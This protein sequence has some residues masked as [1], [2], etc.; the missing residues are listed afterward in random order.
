MATDN[1]DKTNEVMQWI[2][3][4]I[5]ALKNGDKA[6]ITSHPTPIIQIHT[7]SSGDDIVSQQISLNCNIRSPLAVHTKGRPPL[8]RKQS[9][10]EQIVLKLKE[11]KKKEKGKKEKKEKEKEKE[12]H[13]MHDA[14]RGAGLCPQ[15]P[16]TF[17][18][19]ELHP[20]Q[21][22]NAF[23]GAGICPQMPNAFHG[24]GCHSIYECS[25]LSWSLE[26]ETD[27]QKWVS[28]NVENHRKKTTLGTEAVAGR[29]KVVLDSKLRKAEL[30]K[31][32]MTVCQ[33]GSCDFKSI[34]EAIDSIPLNN[35]KRVILEIKPGLYR[36]KIVIPMEMPFITFLG[37]SLNPPTIT[38]NDT[39]SAK[40]MDGR[41]LKTFHRATVAV[42]SN[43]FVAI[44]IIFEV[45]VPDPFGSGSG[46]SIGSSDPV[47][48]GSAG[49]RGY[50]PVLSY[51]FFIFSHKTYLYFIFSGLHYFKNCFIQGSVDFIFGY[52]RSLYE[53]CYLNSVAK[54][55]A[56]VTAQKRTNSSMS[57]G[58]S[59]K[60][61]VVTGSGL[62]YLGRAWGDRS[63]VVF[64][65]TFMDKVVMSQGWND[66]GDQKRETSSLSWSLERESDYQKWVSWNVENHRKQTI[67]GTEA[68]A[69]RGKTELDWKL[70]KAELH[71]VRMT[72]SQD[73]SCDFK[74]IREAIESIPLNNTK[75]VILEIKPGLYREKIV[76]PMEMPFITFLGDSLNPP[77]ITGNDTASTKGQDG[78]PL[79]TFHSATVAVDSNYFVA[80]NIIFENT[81]PHD[82]GSEGE[83]AVA[84]RISGSKAAF[85]NC[86][87]YGTQDTL[88]DHRGLHYFKNCFIQGSVDFIFGFG[89]SLYENC[90]LNSVAKTV[91]SVTAQKRTNSSMSSGFSFKNSVVTGSGLLYLGRAW[92]DRSRVVFSFT[93]MDKAVMSQGWNDWGDQKRETSVYY[94]EYKC[95]GPGANSTG[96]VPWSRLL[97]D[98]EAR[99][100]IGTY[101]VEGD[102]WLL[103]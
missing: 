91:A 2:N 37:D 93:F 75:R 40:G 10:V 22:H 102:T 14:F 82:I 89:R 6:F 48:L 64:S 96:R 35:T 41:P 90:Y 27:Y 94:G 8:K 65:F 86:S 97:N 67:F 59:F 49:T 15:M 32:R 55:V 29:R 9:K 5:N 4:L 68:A 11:K 20:H 63:R 79:K 24:T 12:P 50:I 7:S 73:G 25:S 53:N 58:F 99:P 85:Y 42:N 39:A 87:F 46:T 95:S 76:I 13:Q 30:H 36:E 62:L 74:S 3:S 38:G 28:W 52:G 92:G 81:A 57:S 71:K 103:S 31:V 100:F 45:P 88:Y 69:A 101:Y 78:T 44:N 21:I 34:R 18:G 61:S 33:D 56:S 72:V 98:D 16:N 77:T 84:L 70:R 80:I 54:T 47:P 43:Y 23:N 51:Y 83:Q 26:R 1:E 19:A 66:W 60:D 17:N